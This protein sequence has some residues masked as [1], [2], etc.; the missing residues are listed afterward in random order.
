MLC[1]KH[2][3]VLHEGCSDG[4]NL[5]RIVSLAESRCSMRRLADIP[6][7]EGIMINEPENGALEAV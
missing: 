1:L 4:L 6:R 7:Q 3:N 2:G 5:K